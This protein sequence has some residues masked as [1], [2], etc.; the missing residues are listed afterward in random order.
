MVTVMSQGSRRSPSANSAASPRQRAASAADTA[1]HQ[2]G[3]ALTP[4][5]WRRTLSLAAAVRTS[6]TQRR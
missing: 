1:I 2:S 6:A 5:S 4:S 3:Q